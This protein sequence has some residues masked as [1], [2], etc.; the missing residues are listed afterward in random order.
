MIN[1]FGNKKIINDPRQQRNLPRDLVLRYYRC[2]KW[3]YIIEN[4]NK[5]EHRMHL[6]QKRSAVTVVTIMSLLQKKPIFG[7]LLGP[8]D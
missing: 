5:Y 6:F 4:R 1:F 3:G 2:P 8:Y 7:P